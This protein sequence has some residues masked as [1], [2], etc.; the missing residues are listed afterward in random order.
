MGRFH[1]HRWLFVVTASISVQLFAQQNSAFLDRS[2]VTVT[3][4]EDGTVSGNDPLK[5][6]IKRED[7]SQFCTKVVAAAVMVEAV[8]QTAP[9]NGTIYV[10]STKYD[11]FY[12]QYQTAGAVHAWIS[13][14]YVGGHG[15]IRLPDLKHGLCNININD[16]SPVP[17]LVPPLLTNNSDVSSDSKPFAVRPLDFCKAVGWGK[18]YEKTYVVRTKWDDDSTGDTQ[19]TMTIQCAS[20]TYSAS[21]AP[22]HFSVD[23]FGKVTGSTKTTLHP[24]VNGGPPCRCNA[25]KTEFIDC[26][27]WV[28]AKTYPGTWFIP[29]Q[30]FAPHTQPSKVG[31]WGGQ[32]SSPPCSNDAANLDVVLATESEI[33]DLCKTSGGAKSVTRARRVAL[34]FH[35][36]FDRTFVAPAY[37]DVEFDVTCTPATAGNVAAPTKTNP[38][39]GTPM[40]MN[41]PTPGQNAFPWGKKWTP[42]FAPA[43]RVSAAWLNGVTTSISTVQGT[44]GVIMNA[45]GEMVA[46]F[47]I[48]ADGSVTGGPRGCDY[49]GRFDPST[50]TLLLTQTVP[51]PTCRAAYGSRIWVSISN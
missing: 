32:I 40:P 13:L 25:N 30:P 3:I 33:A 42:N 47:R 36:E 26:V 34:D 2:N 31:E 28:E 43:G 19:Y 14:S 12:P 50:S 4:H 16:V 29:G 6:T 24:M 46:T 27:S 5:L 41:N 35:K 21:V 44:T 39:E 49:A 8:P 22:M 20:N 17:Y 10:G 23:P 18:S 51:N 37:D 11:Q 1:A 9:M 48:N 7:H 15:Y 38:P 45:K